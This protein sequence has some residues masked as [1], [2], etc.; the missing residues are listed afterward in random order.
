MDG[1][2]DIASV[3]ALIGDPGRARVLRALGDGRSL[4]AT[5]LAFEAGVAA[6][7]LARLVAAGLLRVEVRGRHR[8]YR[9]A[10]ADVASA[11]EALARIAPL[12]PVRSLRAGTRAAAV[13]YARSCYDH[14]AGRLGVA[15]MQALLRADALAGDEDGY[16]LTGR[17]LRLLDELGV[18]LPAGRRPL[19]RHCV[20]WSEQRP[21]L[22][23][24]VGAGVLSRLLEL[25][26][27][28]RAPSSRALLVTEIGA[29]QLCR[30][31]G[32]EVRP[33][34]RGL[35]VNATIRAETTNAPAIRA[36]AG[37]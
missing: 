17:G 15:L 21:H 5:V 36:S 6:S 12:E 37:A 24:A 3:A 20:D 29:R 18:R 14:L 34:Q 22:A 2:A 32:V 26:W 31:L 8:Y 1:D 7:H 27:L 10:G 13:R 19:V 25:G 9:L 30:R 35:G 28:E 11:L 16:E 33:G 23:G 4:P